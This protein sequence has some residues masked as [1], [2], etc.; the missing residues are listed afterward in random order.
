MKSK[1]ISAWLVALL[2][3][4]L[5]GVVMGQSHSAWMM[6]KGT[7]RIPFTTTPSGHGDP[8]SYSVAPQIPPYP[9]VQW[10]EAPD[11]EQINY[12]APSLHCGQKVNCLRHGVYNFY[13]TELRF[14][15]NFQL[16]TLQLKIWSLDEGA[17][18]T[19]TNDKHPNGVTPQNGFVKQEISK[20]T[21]RFKESVMTPDLSSYFDTKSTNIVVVTH[22]D[23]C[24][25]AMVLEKIQFLV[26]GKQAHYN[27]PPTFQTAALP[28]V[29]SGKTYSYIAK[30]QDRDQDPLTYTL[31]KG[32][33]K[34][35]VN[36]VS[37]EVQWQPGTQ[38][39]AEFSLQVCDDKMVC[40]RQDWQVIVGTGANR[41]PV[42]HSTPPV[43]VREEKLYTYQVSVTD[44]N[45]WDLMQLK[46]TM[47]KSPVGAT[48][49]SETGEVH[50][51]APYGMGGKVVEF[52]LEVCD[53]SK[54]CTQQSWQVVVRSIP[55]PR[56]STVPPPK[57][58][59]KAT[60]TYQP[61]LWQP[62]PDLKYTWQ[63]VSGPNVYL[64][65]TTGLFQWAQVTHSAKAMHFK[66][67]VCDP[68]HQCTEQAWD[69]QTIA[70]TTKEW[71]FSSIGPRITNIGESYKR[72]FVASPA[73]ETWTYSLLTAVRGANLSGN[74][75]E[76]VP[77]AIWAGKD[78]PFQLKACN[79][80]GW[81][82]TIS[83]TVKVLHQNRP[84]VVT[85]TPLGTGEGRRPYSYKVAATDPDH[86]SRLT[87]SML[88][89]GPKDA[90]H[91][92]L[93]GT[94]EWTPSDSYVGKVVRFVLEVCDGLEA[95]TEQRWNV[96]IKGTYVPNTAPQILSTPLTIAHEGQLYVYEFDAS[97]LHTP[98]EKLIY[99]LTAG[100]KE[101]SITRDHSLQWRPTK[102][103]C[104]KT[105]I[106]AI[107]VCDGSICT[108]Q[109]WLVKA[110]VSRPD[111]R[112]PGFFVHPKACKHNEECEM[113]TSC[114][115]A[116]CVVV[117]KQD[118]TLPP[119]HS[120][121]GETHPQPPQT[122]PTVTAM[123][124]SLGCSATTPQTPPSLL[125]GIWAL[126]FVLWGLRH[127][128]RRGL[129]GS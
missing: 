40:A 71:V 92:P 3:L 65:E 47:H 122:P 99:K 8:V 125:W 76:W 60:Y 7:K 20:K 87:F 21:G 68:F 19:I 46:W 10:L 105:H 126:F 43:L 80:Q 52:L 113:G 42:F 107:E 75:I 66:I 36:S 55:A 112:A 62:E 98:K 91:D 51:K 96:L 25:S 30:A 95:C 49:D 81:C 77:D 83:W 22:L 121:K 15:A 127:K 118:V 88:K 53:L 84:P 111:P 14:P 116:Q 29:A 115:Q 31:L 57:A 32:P 48:F 110:R 11:V 109:S 108:G 69:V 74:I 93:T 5:P 129:R 24:C 33:P 26:N 16:A 13:R 4:L 12:R 67:K 128:R 59:T 97:D 102:E 106:F 39:Q 45:H 90:T 27:N 9:G 73:G 64:N 17:R 79:S 34:S 38:Q 119:I 58:S 1:S 18:V 104:N 23:D 103:E 94:L 2:A 54:S 63:L 41:P 89:E 86:F 28:F 123:N 120:S 114:F 56:L 101:A 85:S 35:S 70:P 61:V 44:P 78:A 100:P 6:V 50:W 117:N 37:G 72:N 124:T 82:K